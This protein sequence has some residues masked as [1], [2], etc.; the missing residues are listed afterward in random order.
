MKYSKFAFFTSL[1]FLTIFASA[2]AQKQQE[3]AKSINQPMT[4]QV[5][6]NNEVDKFLNILKAAVT[7]DDPNELAKFISYPCRW[8]RASGAMMINNES[9]FIK[10]YKLIM[11]KVVKDSILASKA[12]RLVATNQG[13]ASDGGRI[14]FDLKKGIFVV[15]TLD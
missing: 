12:N 15:N 2:N 14:W 5:N 9:D 11:N 3:V 10:S 1:I 13:Y 7:K 6:S 8:N 4:G